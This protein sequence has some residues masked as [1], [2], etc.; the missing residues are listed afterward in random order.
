MMSRAAEGGKEDTGKGR[1]RG[2]L[3]ERG[4]SASHEEEEC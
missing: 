4:W 2:V 1:R 3:D